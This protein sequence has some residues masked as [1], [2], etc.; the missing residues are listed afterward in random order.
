ML[1]FKNWQVRF[2]T[3]LDDLDEPIGLN[4]GLRFE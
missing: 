2:N 1:H 3:F 4:L